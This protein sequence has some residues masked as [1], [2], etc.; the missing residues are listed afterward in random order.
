MDNLPD[1]L[2]DIIYGYSHNINEV[3][4]EIKND[5]IYLST[6]YLS[7][8]YMKGKITLYYNRDKYNYMNAILRERIIEKIKESLKKY[9]FTT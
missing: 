3:C 9:S 4:N 6:S 1:D 7:A 5:I 8:V 2:K